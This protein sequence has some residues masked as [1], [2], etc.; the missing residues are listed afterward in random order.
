MVFPRWTRAQKRQEETG[1]VPDYELWTAASGIRTGEVGYITERPKCDQAGRNWE[2]YCNAEYDEAFNLSQS[3]AS[4]EERL[5]G[6]Y[7]MAELFNQ[8]VLR[9]PLFVVPETIQLLLVM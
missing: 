6:Y 5:E 2:R 7:K 4:E 8:D 3:P 1:E 9:I